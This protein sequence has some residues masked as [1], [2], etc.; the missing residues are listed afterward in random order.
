MDRGR[1]VSVAEAA[2]MLGAGVTP[3]NVR[4]RIRRGSLRANRGKDQE[5]RIALCDLRQL[6]EELEP[7]GNCGEPATRYVIVK[8]PHHD[9]IEY[10]LCAAC[11][12]QAEAA[13][14]RQ[15]N[16]LETVVYPLLGEGW[17]KP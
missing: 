8:Y 10:A 13:Y 9:R 6:L 7:C 3:E 4:A 1:T 14:S 15:G 11:A 12:F 17:L 16:V 2:E 5:W